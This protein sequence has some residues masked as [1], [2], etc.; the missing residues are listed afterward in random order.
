MSILKRKK[1]KK[2]VGKKWLGMRH[3]SHLKTLFPFA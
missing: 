2:V 1:I 3:P